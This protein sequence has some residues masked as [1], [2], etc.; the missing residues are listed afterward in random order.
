MNWGFDQDIQT[1]KTIENTDSVGTEPTTVTPVSNYD[2]WNSTFTV[3]FE[4]GDKFYVEV[5]DYDPI[6]DDWIGSTAHATA[7]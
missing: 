5:Y 1:T 3:K 6:S 4:T 2:M 7:D